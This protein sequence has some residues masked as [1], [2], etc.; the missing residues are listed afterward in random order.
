MNLI[1]SICIGWGLI[2]EMNFHQLIKRRINETL[3]VH[4][5]INRSYDI[6]TYKDITYEIFE[7]PSPEI[8]I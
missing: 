2:K 4:E 1:F 5:I 7:H 3:V 6:V 8:E